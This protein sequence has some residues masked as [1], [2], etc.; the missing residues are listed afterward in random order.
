MVRLAFEQQAWTMVF[1]ESNESYAGDQIAR[2][3]TGTKPALRDESNPSGTTAKY[4][5]CFFLNSGKWI[6][7]RSGEWNH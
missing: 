4:P 7:K 3:G 6:G 1:E 5:D 2:R